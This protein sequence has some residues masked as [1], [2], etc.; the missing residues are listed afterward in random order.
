MTKEEIIEHLINDRHHGIY[1]AKIAAEAGLKP[2]DIYDFMRSTRAR[3]LW[4]V[5]AALEEYYT[6]KGDNK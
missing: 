6:N 3:P 5:A 4:R 1:Y 2:Q